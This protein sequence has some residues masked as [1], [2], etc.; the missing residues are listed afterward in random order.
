MEIP[1]S[2]ITETASKAFEKAG[3]IVQDRLF[4]P[5]YFYFLISWVITNWKFVYT[6]LFVDQE[7]ILKMQG[8]LKVD[9]MAQMYHLD[10][11][12]ALHLFI[13]PLISSFVFVWWLSLISKKFYQKHE[14]NQ[15]E[16]RT[17]LRK[18]EYTEKVE[19][20]K[21]ER[22][23]REAVFDIQIKYEEHADFNDSFDEDYEKITFGKITLLPSKVLYATDYEAYKEALVDFQN[24]EI[25]DK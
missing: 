25:D 18:I 2:K 21:S 11:S 10:V 20:A 19:Q 16:K 22:E 5:M 17:V 6:L 1:L 13:I 7:T 8:I 9:Y 3:E 4:S 23:I 14:E 12:S 24:R 15:M